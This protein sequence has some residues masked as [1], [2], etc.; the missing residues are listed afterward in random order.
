MQISSYQC[1]PQYSSV[2]LRF[3][4]R[5]DKIIASL[6]PSETAHSFEGQ[7][8]LSVR[9]LFCCCSVKASSDKTFIFKTKALSFIYSHKHRGYGWGKQIPFFLP[10]RWHKAQSSVVRTRG[11]NGIWKRG[12]QFDMLSQ[13]QTRCFV[14]SIKSSLP[15]TLCHY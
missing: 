10:L 2:V 14:S 5:N 9:S 11:V 3:I 15:T 8:C 12:T 4:V 13:R 6:V 1:S 7:P